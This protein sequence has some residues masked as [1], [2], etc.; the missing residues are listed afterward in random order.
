M[1]FTDVTVGEAALL[2]PSK[3]KI[4]APYFFDITLA[5]RIGVPHYK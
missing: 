2:S 4:P 5:G 1:V 3:M